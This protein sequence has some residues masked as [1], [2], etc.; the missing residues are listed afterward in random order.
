MKIALI[1]MGLVILGLV[2]VVV[3]YVHAVN[4]GKAVLEFYLVKYGEK[5]IDVQDLLN[6]NY[7]NDYKVSKLKIMFRDDYI[8][9]A[10]RIAEQLKEEGILK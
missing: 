2:Y 6:S 5:Y 4:T 9:G 8:E 3:S 1:I 10:K 7:D